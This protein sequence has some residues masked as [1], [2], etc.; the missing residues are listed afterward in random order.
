MTTLAQKGM[1]AISSAALAI[2]VFMV[3]TTIFR[4]LGM[5]CESTY[6]LEQGL[7]Q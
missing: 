3:T 2:I 7:E 1:T 6:C 5:V 4:K